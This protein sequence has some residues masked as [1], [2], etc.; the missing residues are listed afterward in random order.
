MYSQLKEEWKSIC[1]NDPS[2]VSML[3]EK[4]SP[5]LNHKEEEFVKQG[6]DLLEQLGSCCLVFILEEKK[7]SF[8]I[9]E[10]YSGNVRAVERCVILEVSKE[11]SDWFELFDTGSF[12]AM[13]PRAME[14]TEWSSLSENLQ[15]RLLK[16]VGQ[17]VEVPGKKYAIGKYQV[18]QAL[19]ES[20]MGSNPSD[21][22]GSSRP[23]E[24]VNWF[25]CI[26]F[27]N[28][29]SEKE[30][31]EKAYTINGKEVQC[32]FESNG[33]RL[34]TEWEW[35]FAAKANE[36]YYEYSG[37]DDIYEVAWYG[38]NS[39]RQTHGVGQKKPNGFG[40]YDMNGN[41]LEWCWDWFEGD[42][43][44]IPTEDS[45][46]PSTGSDRMLR[47]GCWDDVARDGRVAYRQWSYPSCRVGS[48]GFRF[49]R[50]IR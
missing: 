30:G 22:K 37:S 45:I 6:M 24:M 40:L 13:Y 48:L 3:E 21:F 25:D 46:G 4:L 10:K 9:S 19:W 26:E 20:V 35:Y 43:E 23:V 1:E 17:L 50:T 27:C 38:E 2:L 44:D 29:L 16:E 39:N 36:D 28:K 41:V 18:T 12:D 7:G 47:G 42:R 8:E 15:Q 34:P 5:L 49:S 33:Y 32:N 11:D 14:N 31:L